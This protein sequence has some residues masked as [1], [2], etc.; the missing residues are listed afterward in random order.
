[1]IEACLRLLRIALVRIVVFFVLIMLVFFV[2]VFIIG[3]FSKMGSASYRPIKGD[4]VKVW[5]IHSRIPQWYASPLLATTG[6]AGCYNDC[7]GGYVLL[8]F[9]VL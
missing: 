1:M 2:V 9:Q 8:L 6:L 4:T 7:G 5:W 3:L